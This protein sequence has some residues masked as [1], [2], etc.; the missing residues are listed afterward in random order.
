MHPKS[1]AAMCAMSTL[2]SLSTWVGAQ[3]SPTPS[4]VAATTS[5]ESPAPSTAT[6]PGD[7]AVAPNQLR[8]NPPRTAKPASSAE[9]QS[10]AT[11]EAAAPD[12]QN[13]KGG[14]GVVVIGASTATVVLAVILL[15]VLL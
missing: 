10:Y 6:V 9:R 2:L 4:H 1:I 15:V 11:R 3:A 14:E 5:N 8:A 7:T 12:A 13:Y